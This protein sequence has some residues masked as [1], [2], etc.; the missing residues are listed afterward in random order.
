[1]CSEPLNCLIG[2]GETEIDVDS[3]IEWIEGFD[4]L[5]K[6]ATYVPLQS[7]RLD[8]SVNSRYWQSSDGLASGNNLGE[9]ILH[10]LLERVERDSETLAKLERPATWA[11]RCIDPAIFADPVVDALVGRIQEAGFVVRLFDIGSDIGIPCFAALLAP[12]TSGI[13]EFRY[14]D[15]ANGSGAHPVPARA[16]IRAIT[17]A[18]QSRLTLISG[19]RDDIAPDTYG[20]ELPAHIVNDL[21]T[22]PNL[23]R[24]VLRPKHHPGGLLPTV[25]GQLTDAG[26]RSAI[27]VHLNP[28][29]R[30][31]AVAKILV[32]QLEN[33]AGARKHRFGMRAVIKMLACT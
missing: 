5:Q 20:S 31:F 17:E 19:A 10:G 11:R 9:A 1:M 29:N 2:A 30:D 4:L 7:V 16:A 8:R 12:A 28:E 25:L 26:I 27:S 18:A 13:K 24:P 3:P 22:K 32:P 33:P 21:L 15:V 14:I 23:H 6:Q